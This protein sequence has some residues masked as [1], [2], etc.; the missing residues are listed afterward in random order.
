MLTRRSFLF[1]T[2]AVIASPAIAQQYPSM[3]IFEELRR[4]RVPSPIIPMPPIRPQCVDRGEERIGYHGFEHCRLHNDYVW[5]FA[6]WNCQCYTGQ[7]RPTMFR[8]VPHVPDP[9]GKYIPGYEIYV[10]GVYYPI[11]RAAFRT[12]K[13]D[14][15]SALL[16]YDAHV[17]CN[18]ATPERPIP[19]IECAWIKL[20][21]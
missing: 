7:C 18:E 15:S 13:A 21:S 12:E 20:E 11:P 4:R 1:I 10:S 3:E 2:G 6:K 5:A 9:E 14:M 19:H 16:V 17:C 8:A